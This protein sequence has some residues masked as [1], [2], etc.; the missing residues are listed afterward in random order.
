MPD[1]LAVDL[2][3]PHAGRLRGLGVPRGV[4]L[5]VGGG[6]HGKSTLLAA[7]A[8]GVYDHVPGDGRERCVTLPDAV[9]VRAEDGRAVRGA[10]LRPFIGDLRYYTRILKRARAALGNE[11]VNAIRDDHFHF[12]YLGPKLLD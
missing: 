6:Y 2:E 12:Y 1:A 9:T 7:L 8:L 5:I 10:D 4:T 11:R 3:A